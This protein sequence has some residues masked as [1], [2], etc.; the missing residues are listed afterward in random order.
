MHKSFSD[1]I[2]NLT[3]VTEHQ[4]AIQEYLDHALQ[5]KQIKPADDAQQQ[6]LP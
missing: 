6:P 1:Q 5:N 4:K 2:H 3:S